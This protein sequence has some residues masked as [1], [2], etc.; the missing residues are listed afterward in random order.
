M[1]PWQGFQ[2]LK[3]LGSL[4]GLRALAIAGVLWQHCTPV[5]ASSNPFTNA[6][7]SGVSLFFVL[8]GF[9][10]TTLLL[11][12]WRS[13][14]SIDLSAFYWRRTLRILPLYYAT[15]A[16]YCVL[17]AVFDRHSA[18]GRDFFSNLPYFLTYTNNWFVDLAVNA[19][20]ELR[21][22]F[23]FAWTL[24]T[25]EQFYLFWPPI[26]FLLAPKRAFWLLAGIVAIDVVVASSFT[27]LEV[28]AN[29][30]ERM[31]KIIASFSSEI[32]FGCALGGILHE[33]RSFALAWGLLGQWWSIWIAAALSIWMVMGWPEAT[34]GWRVAQAAAFT[35]L[36][37]AAVV[38]PRH[39]LSWLL[40]W[41]PLARIGV[42]SYGM[43]LLHMLA[44]HATEMGFGLIG[45]TEVNSP[46]LLLLTAGLATWVIAELSFRWFESPI[47]ALKSRP[48]WFG[49]G[50]HA[51]RRPNAAETDRSSSLPGAGEPSEAQ[52]ALTMSSDQAVSR[53]ASPGGDGMRLTSPR[54]AAARSFSRRMAS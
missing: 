37:G 44:I 30:A 41:R 18:A 7:A 21:T 40:D 42:V 26:L 5:A 20:G 17:V 31:L 12:E 48:A 19:D 49:L 52:S 13:K 24:A 4:D 9:L 16:V 25:E 51:G 39:G 34:V 14:G 35:M 53:P 54:K 1:S 27:S 43:Y 50:A 46:W 47:L 45:W 33:R 22:I 2:S 3:R 10:I 23:I 11:R 8:S 15:L 38:K 29:G 32:A 36:I 6:G 28:P